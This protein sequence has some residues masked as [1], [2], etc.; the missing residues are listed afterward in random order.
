M[1]I[2]VGPRGLDVV[3]TDGISAAIAEIPAVDLQ[4]PAFWT[5]GALPYS[6]A[7]KLET[8]LQN[9]KE[10]WAHLSSA[11]KTNG[12]IV[13]EN[14]QKLIRYKTNSEKVDPRWIWLPTSLNPEQY[15][16]LT[17]PTMTMVEA[18]N[19]L[20][21]GIQENP[22][23]EQASVHSIEFL[24]RPDVHHPEGTITLTSEYEAGKREEIRVVAA[25][26]PRTGIRFGIDLHRLLDAVNA[27]SPDGGYLTF[28][29]RNQE[30]TQTEPI[31]IRQETDGAFRLEW[32]IA[33]IRL[34][35]QVRK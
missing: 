34:D 8:D 18:A 32:G 20:L 11:G 3:A 22:D 23:Y 1:H 14:N 28:I 29:A 12:Q 26:A 21:S 30:D 25:Q 35:D 15:W 24:W 31:F 6:V 19:R 13:L 2:Q 27:M 16:M 33:P 4:Y 10:W 17:L 5:V 7:K 9:Q